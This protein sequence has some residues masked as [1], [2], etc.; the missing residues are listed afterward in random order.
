MNAPVDIQHSTS[1]QEI[2]STN[3]ILDPNSM[4]SMMDLATFMSK[5][6]VTLPDAY[7]N[8]P[9]NCLAVVM[10][11]VVWKMDPFAIAQK[12]HFINGNIGYEA[13]LV[14]AVISASGVTKGAFNYEFF[15]PWENVI[16]K[17]EIKNSTKDGKTS[18]YRV[19]G[20]K[21]ADEEGI[22][23]KISAT[24]RGEDQPR[25]L[26]LLLA[27]ART[28]NSTMWAD[29]PKQ[30]L[31]YLAQKKWA[32]LFSPGVIL[33]VYTPDEA[34]EMVPK[35]VDVTATGSH[36][37]KK[38]YYTNDEFAEKK[39]GWKAI[40]AE[41]KKTGANLISF[42][43]SKGKLFTEA[44]RTEILAWKGPAKPAEAAASQT[45]T[46][47]EGEAQKVD[48]PFVADLENAETTTAS[49]TKE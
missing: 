27:Q 41:G 20:W 48:D 47:I 45:P 31:C 3:L 37:V 34:D 9:A 16:G 40:V 28:R 7:R 36:E 18:E 8:N 29:D 2:S 26:D 24:L 5:G 14:S 25:T 23:V 49:Q 42:V 33:G 12:T 38:E 22:G 10:K 43:E 30:Q 1:L 6:T 44:Q 13:Q 4:K 21:L 11:A 15:G 39:A 19:P 46:T 17:F 32:R 35:E